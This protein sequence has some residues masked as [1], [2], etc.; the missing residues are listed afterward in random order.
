M[1]TVPVPEI[2]TVK[3]WGDSLS[4]R[5]RLGD[6]APGPR[7]SMYIDSLVFEHIRKLGYGDDGIMA[8]FHGESDGQ[9]GSTSDVL[10]AD[11]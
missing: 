11:P 7:M 5:I 6:K 8:Y 1:V 2:F 9:T 10:P 3:A 4:A